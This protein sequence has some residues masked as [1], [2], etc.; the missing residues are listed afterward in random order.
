MQNGIPAGPFAEI[1]FDCAGSEAPLVTDFA[2][3]LDAS[4]GN[5]DTIAGD[6]SIAIRYE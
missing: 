6:C 2:C 4:D 5:G 3:T 1:T